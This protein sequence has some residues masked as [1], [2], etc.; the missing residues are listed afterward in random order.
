MKQMGTDF[1]PEEE[2]QNA[3]DEIQK[4]EKDTQMIAMVAQTLFEKSDTQNMKIVELEDQ[5]LQLSNNEQL[6]EQKYS[7]LEGAYSNVRQEFERL[8][9]EKN[10]LDRQLTQLQTKKNRLEKQNEIQ[11]KK[12]S[13]QEEQ[14]TQNQAQINDLE[15]NYNQLRLAADSQ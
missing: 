1:D 2:L 9:L 13:S 3:L 4:N 12:L 7:N 14:L 8:E 11:E 15:N 10:E 5:M 6:A